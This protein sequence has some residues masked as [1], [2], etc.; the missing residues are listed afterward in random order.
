MICSYLCLGKR[1][2][3]ISKNAHALSVLRDR[4][5]ISVRDLVVDVSVSEL[6]GM[7]QLQKTVE[8][9]ANRISCTNSEVEGH[10]CALLQVR[11]C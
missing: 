10:K 8:R 4:L 2:V 7:Q 9:L 5:P 1:V 11:F 3:V 6:E